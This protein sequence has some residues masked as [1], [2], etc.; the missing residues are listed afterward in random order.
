MKGLF[1]LRQHA[2]L[3]T[4]KV[5]KYALYETLLFLLLLPLLPSSYL[6]SHLLLGVLLSSQTNFAGRL[7]LSERRLPAPLASPSIIPASLQRGVSYCS[8]NRVINPA[9]G[10][11]LRVTP[12]SN[13]THSHTHT[14]PRVCVCVWETKRGSGSFS[15]RS[16]EPT[17][18]ISVGV[19]CV[20]APTDGQTEINRRVAVIFPRAAF[21]LIPSLPL[22][23][24]QTGA[25][26]KKQSSNPDFLETKGIY[27]TV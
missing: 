19:C 17:A 10:N 21:T 1:S 9:R 4:S 25:G 15:I 22:F 13:H 27:S 7:Y 18:L 12:A 16:P 2:V 20:H 3:Q 5:R 26:G 11:E 14:E 8:P 24:R 6:G 23:R